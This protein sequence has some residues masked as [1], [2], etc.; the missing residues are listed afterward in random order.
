MGPGIRAL[1]RL[2]YRASLG[3]LAEDGVTGVGV[4]DGLLA[5]AW[6]LDD[7]ATPYVAQRS[8]VSGILGFGRLPVPWRSTH[9][10]VPP[11]TPVT[12]PPSPAVAYLVRVEDT[13]ARYLPVLVRADVP[14]AAP[15]TVPLSSAPNRPAPAGFGTVRGEVHARSD[16]RPL[17]WSLVRVDTGTVVSQTVADQ[18]G[19]FAL[20]LPYPE[21]LPVLAGSP[22]AGP[23]LSSVVWP[24]TVT[25]RC[26]PSALTFS[27]PLTADSPELASI[28]GQA[29]AQIVD[30]GANHPS[31]GATLAFG[32]PLVLALTV[33][34]A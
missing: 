23:G 21:A 13:L 4:T 28:T 9:A 33:V 20:H 16:G 8:P 19:R 34:P 15:V 30:G 6:R 14:V 5:T 26:Q 3:I 1:E 25:V 12:W 17:P 10:V 29:A 22:P 11:E 32:T 2:G 27:G 18:R 31:V 7:P 24:L